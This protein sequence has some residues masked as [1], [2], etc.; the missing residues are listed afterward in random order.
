[1]RPLPAEMPTLKDIHKTFGADLQFALI[2]LACDQED[3][4][5]KHKEK[6]WF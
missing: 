1:V 4:A 3:E 5:A 6:L 2:S